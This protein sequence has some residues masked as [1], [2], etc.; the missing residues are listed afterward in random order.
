MGSGRPIRGNP[1]DLQDA[2]L[3]GS[4]GGGKTSTL[5]LLAV[6]MRRHAATLTA[7]EDASARPGVPHEPP[8]L[9]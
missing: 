3:H 2:V 9:D 8:N 5:A 4:I 7:P 6:D 1:D